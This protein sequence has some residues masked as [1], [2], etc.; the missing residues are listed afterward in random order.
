MVVGLRQLMPG[1]LQTASVPRTF[2]S[3]SEGR[4]GDSDLGNCSWLSVS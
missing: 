1:H 2:L 4:E 3:L